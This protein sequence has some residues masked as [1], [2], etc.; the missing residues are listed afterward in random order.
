MVELIETY[1]VEKTCEYREERYRVRD[2]GAIMRLAK[3]G[4]RK[5]PLDGKW[6]FGKPDKQKGYL[7]FSSASVH[8]IVATAF[9]GEQPSEKHVVDHIDTNKKNNRPENL[10]WITRLDNILLNPITLS[11]VIYKYGSIDNFLADPSKPNDGELEQNFE[12]MRTVTKEESENTRKNLLNWASEGKA[13]SGGQ[14]GEWIFEQ[15]GQRKDPNRFEEPLLPSMTS[16]AFQKNWSAPSR[17]PSCPIEISP[18]PIAEYYKGLEIDSLFFENS[19]YRAKV[20]KKL[21]MDA[22]NNILVLYAIEYT[23]NEKRW[24]IMK[25]IYKQGKFIH[26]IVPNYNGSLSHYNFEDTENHFMAIINGKKW[27]PL[28]DSQGRKFKRDYMP[29]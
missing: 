29:L 16:N 17:F 27:T 6:T 25:I 13:P 26:E 4:K 7:Y 24:G 14:L 12:W 15:S 1:E 22:D 10:R 19:S 3:Q 9:H 2:N 11:R 23:N 28:Y 21:M 18:H 20:I 5:R 8:R